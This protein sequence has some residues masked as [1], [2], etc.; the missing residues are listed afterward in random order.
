MR[1]LSSTRI[2]RFVLV[3]LLCLW[4]AGGGCLLGCEGM[5]A[6]NAS[7]VQEKHSGRHSEVKAASGSACKSSSS[8]SCCTKHSGATKAAA[9]QTSKSAALLV[10]LGGSPSGMMK[11]CPLAVGRTA[12]AAKMRDHEVAAAPVL[13]RSIL[14]PESGLER[15]SPLSAPA[16][17]P[18]RGHTYL[19][20]C[21]FLI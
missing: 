5:A 7:S 10:S 9:K 15:T 20:C 2:V 1:M 16:R 13:A 4:V 12:L 8:H 17:L 6:A 18:N 14:P 3:P 21:V 19:R 11:E